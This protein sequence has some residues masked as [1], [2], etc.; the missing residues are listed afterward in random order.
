MAKGLVLYE[1]RS[2]RRLS[3]PTTGQT[4]PGSFAPRGPADRILFT[5]ASRPV[6]FRHNA[7]LVRSNDAFAGVHIVIL[8]YQTPQASIAG[9]L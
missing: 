6:I 4:A 9:Y 2:T 1:P 8:D 5:F 3:I 7:A